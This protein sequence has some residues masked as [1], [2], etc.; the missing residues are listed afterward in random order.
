[1]A[2]GL[3]ID[4]KRQQEDPNRAKQMRPIVEEQMRK[5]GARLAKILEEIVGEP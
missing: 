2:S 1:M 5:A 3:R 4:L